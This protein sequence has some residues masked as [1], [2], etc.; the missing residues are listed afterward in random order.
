VNRL[1]SFILLLL[2]A[3]LFVLSLTGS[4]GLLQLRKIDNETR[5]LEEKN[6]ELSEELT[7]VSNEIYGVKQSDFVLEKRGREKLGLAK[8]NEIVYIF[9][10]GKQPSEV[11]KTE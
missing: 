11:R 6:Q 5:S 4:H 2:S 8:P 10:E 1:T 9:P 3:V 7:K